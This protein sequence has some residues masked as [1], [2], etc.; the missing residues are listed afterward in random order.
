MVSDKPVSDKPE[1]GKTYRHYKGGRYHVNALCTHTET[2]EI[3]VAYQSLDHKNAA[4]EP[5]QWVRPLTEWNR[6]IEG[7]GLRFMRVDF[8]D[9]LRDAP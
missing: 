2:N 3:M 7:G 5:A 6:P 9:L 1:V 4:G 8:P